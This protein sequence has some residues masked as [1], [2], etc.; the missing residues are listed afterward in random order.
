MFHYTP[1]EKICIFIKDNTDSGGGGAT[2]LPHNSVRIEISPYS[3]DY[4]F[5]HFGQQIQWLL[6]HELVH[7]VT[8]DQYSKPVSGL[9]KLLGK[10]AP[11][12]DEPF[13]VPFGILTN[14]Y[15][16]QPTWYH[17]GIAVFMETW[18]NGGYGRVLGSFDEMYFRT[19]VEEGTPYPKK[20]R[21]DFMDDDSFLLGSTAYFYGARFTAWLTTHYDLDRMLDFMTVNKNQSQ[22]HIHYKKEFKTLFGTSLDKAWKEFLAAET[23]FQKR[24]CNESINTRN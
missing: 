23:A 6:S 11:G 15:R 7:I 12:K 9:R 8:S 2:T 19:L 3:F 10:I 14:P 17:E 5:T 4:E 24:T 21:M 18:E 1:S 13:S 20:S 16:F 22:L